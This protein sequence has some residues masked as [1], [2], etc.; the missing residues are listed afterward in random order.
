MNTVRRLPLLALSLALLTFLMAPLPVQSA[1]PDTPAAGMAREELNL[2]GTWDM[3]VTADPAYPPR[4]AK[5]EAAS[6]PVMAQS[7]AINGT[8]Y[9]WYRKELNVPD[10]FR[11]KRT[12]LL[13][14]GARFNATVYCDGVQ[15]A[16]RLEGYTPFSID[17]TRRARPGAKLLLEIR[18]QDWSAVFKDDFRL[19]ADADPDGERLRGV[20]RGKLIAPIGGHFSSFGLWDDVLLTARPE[21]HCE[22]VAIVT[23]V[24]NNNTLTITGAAAGGRPGQWIEGA[25]LED[26]KTALALPGAAVGADLKFSLSVRFPGA[27]Y[28]SPEDP[29]RYTLVLS[30]KDG[31]ADALLDRY[32][33]RFGFRELWTVGPDF[34]LNG[35]KRHLLAS[36]G[37]PQP[38]YMSPAEIRQGITDLKSSHAVAFRLH[39]Q[40]WQRRWLEEADDL[41]LMIVEEGALW[42]DGGGGYAY[43]DDRFWRNVQ[44][45]LAGMVAR[46]RNHPSLVM[47]S[48]ENELLHCGAS[49]KCA[50]AE[51]RLA[52]AGRQVKALDPTHLI[53]YE[54]DHDPEGVAD[55]IGLHYPRE[56]PDHSDYPNTADW[57]GTTVTTG[58]A[59]NTAGSWNKDFFWERKKPLYIGEYLWVF[60]QDYSA[61]TVF[62]GDEAYLDKQAYHDKAKADAWVFQTVAYRRAG[63]SG[64]CPW[65]IAGNGGQVD[66]KSPLFA[67][68][69]Y[70]YEPVAIYPREADTRF[71]TG[72]KAVRSFDVF[73]D[74]VTPLTI[75]VRV[76]MSGWASG[77]TE[78]F[79]LEPAGHKVVTVTVPLPAKGASEGLAFSAV[80]ASGGKIIHS[81][82]T[83]YFV[84]DR[85]QPVLPSGRTLLIYDPAQKWPGGR[86]V[87]GAVVLKSLEALSKADPVKSVLIIGPDAFQKNKEAGAA[88]VIGDRHTTAAAFR[89]FLSA[90]GRALVLEQESLRDLMPSLEL[91]DHASTMTFAASAGH[92]LLSGLSAAD[93]KFWRN[94]HYVSR[95]EFIRPGKLG[96]R[97]IV[98]SGGINCVDQA[99]VVEM[100]VGRGGAVFCQALAGAKYDTEPAARRF[101]ANAIA[102]LAA[103]SNRSTAALVVAEGKDAA[104]F[105]RRLDD[106]GLEYAEAAGLPQKA[107]VDRAGLLILSGGGSRIEALAPL[108]TGLTRPLTVYWHAPEKISFDKMKSVLGLEKTEIV[109]ATGPML[110]L[111]ER[112]Q[113]GSPAAGLLA[114][115]I[116]FMAPFTA[117]NW[118]REVTP[119]AS[120]IDRA[121][122]LLSVGGAANR[123]ELKTWSLTGALVRLTDGTTAAFYTN[124]TAAGEITVPKAGLYRLT[125][126]AWGTPAEDGWP[127]VLIKAN[128][129]AVAQV[130][131]TDK[132]PKSYACLARLPAGTLKIELVYDND[133]YIKGEDRNLFL[134]TFNVSREPLDPGSLS[135]YSLPPALAAAQSKGGLRAVVDCVRWDTNAGN[136]NRGLRYASTLLANL[137]ASFTSSRASPD[138]ISL[139]AFEPLG[140]ISVFSRTETQLSFGSN[141]AVK[142][143]FTC[144][145]A[146]E[147][148]VIVRG[149]ATS[150]RGVYGKARVKIDGQVVGEPELASPFAAEFTAGRVKLTSGSHEI[151]VEFTNDLWLGAGKEDRNLYVT[152]VGFLSEGGA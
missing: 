40:P 130:T 148:A 137:G 65:T 49:G 107:D 125:I 46:D 18:C 71:F 145:A 135:L 128:G 114:E 58:T 131:V 83:R 39:T 35:V 3:A 34:Y 33:E 127:L 82:E 124:G 31:R 36:S 94:D 27:H 24:R 77:Y 126:E 28:W 92:P 51:T 76:T 86:L 89:Q 67:A 23:S 123:Y 141:G 122:Q 98:V 115:D 13:L 95:R 99:V 100:A 143:G 104:D 12:D 79:T 38:R 16:S 136:R 11:G 20:P 56:M 41:G 17:L 52:E 146:G 117:A 55:V 50:C 78:K 121:L 106:L 8:R 1:P 42:C 4:V 129:T 61:G 105:K 25:V 109:R 62:Y 75:E 19:P 101:V 118:Y 74:G 29:H 37:W 60:Q 132:E 21:T 108:I 43:D 119:D 5:W 15:V 32:E 147:Y 26:G 116:T 113:A 144:A 80:L 10:S 45:H 47:W 120:V 63:V 2:N 140:S 64:M 133:L 97:P 90:G 139:V 30:L 111:P 44:A 72:E 57:L 134:R 14:A 93:L 6:V 53:T 112:D 9:V 152:G 84:S 149:F 73:N 69:S 150:A 88:P 91:T 142:S 81:F 110:W 96:A 54:A 59:G 68:Q 7:N 87:A 138:W 102:W 70:A 85:K 66:K 151:T 103:Y 48:I 22:D